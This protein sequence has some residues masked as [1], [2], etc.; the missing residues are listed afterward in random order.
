VI[1]GKRPRAGVWTP[2]RRR[3]RLGTWSL[4][5]LAVDVVVE[6]GLAVLGEPAELDP[7]GKW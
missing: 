5:V 2:W 6:A 3:M 7:G 4:P 1:R